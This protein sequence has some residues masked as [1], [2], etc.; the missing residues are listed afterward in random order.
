MNTKI[1]NYVNVLFAEVP[2]S[3]RA[4]ELKEELLS[5]MSER[6]EDYIAQGKTETQ[7]YSLVVSNM[8]DLDALLEEVMPNADFKKEAQ[9]YRTRNAKNTA[10]GVSMYILGA[11]ILIGFAGIGEYLGLEDAFAMLGVVILLVLAAIATGLIV[12]THMSTPQE[13]KD[14]DQQEQKERRLYATT[15]GKVFESLMSIYWLIVTLIYLAI[16]FFTGK[17]GTTWMIWVLAGILSEIIKVIFEMRYLDE[18]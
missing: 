12:Y 11:A 9:N 2:R 8:G 17:W 3:K 13:Y 16:S 6:F 10:I 7:A 1:T 18:K 14:Y 15:G 5:N 4:S